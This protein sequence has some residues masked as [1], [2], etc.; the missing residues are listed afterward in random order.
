[1][2]DGVSGAVRG[3]AAGRCSGGASGGDVVPVVP[4]PGIWGIAVHIR[5]QRTAGMGAQSQA[6][7]SA[8][9][10]AVHRFTVLCERLAIDMLRETDVLGAARLLRLSW[11]EAG[12]L[13]ERVVKRGLQSKGM[14]SCRRSGMDEKSVTK[15]QQ[16][17]TLVGDLD[18][19][20]VEYIADWCKQENLDGYFQSLT[21]EQRA[22]IEAIALDMWEPYVQSIR[23]H[24]RRPSTRWYLT[25]IIS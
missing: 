13:M 14:G 22:G 12:A 8:V 16:Y 5:P 1:V 23:V 9:E 10:G 25:A 3:Q 24:V 15:G 19:G 6:G 20:T 2:D 4:M 7:A 21:A 11:D 18:Q 17:F